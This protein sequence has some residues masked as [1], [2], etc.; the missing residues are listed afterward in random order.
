[1]TGQRSPGVR[2]I[3]C[4]TRK[5]VQYGGQEDACTPPQLTLELGCVQAPASV[6]DG[7]VL[8]GQANQQMMTTEANQVILPAGSQALSTTA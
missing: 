3:L 7:S 2:K 1:M 4:L 6:R 8:R 5:D